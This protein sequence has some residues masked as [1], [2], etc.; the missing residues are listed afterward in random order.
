M[1]SPRDLRTPTYESEQGQ[2]NAG[3]RK[4]ALRTVLKQQRA[5]KPEGHSAFASF[6][7]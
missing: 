6:C 3:P 2:L 7:H 1:D 4:R 5:Y